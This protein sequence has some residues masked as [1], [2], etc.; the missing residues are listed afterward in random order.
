MDAQLPE[1]LRLSLKGPLPGPRVA[2]RYEPDFRPGSHYD[3]VPEDARQAAVL[4]LLYPHEDRWHVPLTLRPDHLPDHAGQVSLPG[5]AIEPGES[6]G[7]A[8]LREFHEELD[9][10]DMS[11]ELLGQLTPLFV[12][13]SNFLVHPWLGVADRRDRMTPNPNEVD[14]LLEVPLDHLLNP[15]SFGSHQRQ[16]EGHTYVVPHFQWQSYQI[17]GATCMILGELVTLVRGE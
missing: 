16:R 2:S 4:V 12:R 9:G 6:S 14:A 10:Q 13:V 17:W 3:T 8:A 1:R 11:I 5:G 15:A 7:E